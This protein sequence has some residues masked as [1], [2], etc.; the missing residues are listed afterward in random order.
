MGE[1]EVHARLRK[2]HVAGQ[3]VMKHQGAAGLVGS[4]E[5]PEEKARGRQKD[6]EREGARSQEAMM[7]RLRRLNFNLWATKSL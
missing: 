2:E 3:G 7:S 4:S 1:E 6:K 5:R